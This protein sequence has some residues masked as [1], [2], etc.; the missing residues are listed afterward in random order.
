MYF[1][2]EYHWSAAYIQEFILRNS[3]LNVIRHNFSYSYE[4]ITQ[5]PQEK[6]YLQLLDK[7]FVFDHNQNT[8]KLIFITELALSVNYVQN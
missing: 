4:K 6:L 2:S 8:N 5:K 3:I 7:S 1:L